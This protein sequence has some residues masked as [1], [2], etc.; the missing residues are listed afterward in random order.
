MLNYGGFSLKKV[1]SKWKHAFKMCLANGNMQNLMPRLLLADAFDRACANDFKKSVVGVTV[2]ELFRA[3]FTENGYQ[4]VVSNIT[5]SLWEKTKDG[6][7]NVTQFIQTNN[8]IPD[9]KSLHEWYNRGAVYVGREKSEFEIVAPLIYGS[10]VSALTVVSDFDT[11]DDPN[12]LKI[13]SSLPQISL[14]FNQEWQESDCSPLTVSEE[15][16]KISIELNSFDCI[17]QN[18]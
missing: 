13:T 14:F 3:L 10:L 9:S 11:F 1:V 16:N 15:G 17:Q 4:N 6:I 8:H 18:W 12:M 5:P 7:I 2:D